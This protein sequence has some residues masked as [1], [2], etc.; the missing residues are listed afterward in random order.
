MNLVVSSHSSLISKI[1]SQQ[2]Y[3]QIFRIK[4]RAAELN[5]KMRKCE[6]LKQSLLEQ[7]EA[8]NKLPS[9]LLRR[10]FNGEL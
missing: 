6:K 1:M 5:E 9:A 4:L 7:L 10:A 3:E 8:I 2:L